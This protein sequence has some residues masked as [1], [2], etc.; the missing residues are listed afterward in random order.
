MS[1]PVQPATALV[2]VDDGVL[3]I[4]RLAVTDPAVLTAARSAQPRRESLADWARTALHA[5]AVAITAAG[6]GSDLAGV[7][8]ALD[9]L[10]RSVE[11]SVQDGVA[12][13][14]TG[15]DATVPIRVQAAIR[16]VLDGALP[17]ITR[18]LTATASET[19]RAVS[20][21]REAVRAAVSATVRDQCAELVRQIREIHTQL[22]LQAAF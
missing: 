11:N 19:Q 17:G 16:D 14:V 6:H 12:W 8:V 9:G 15:P 5:G 10:T 20:I 13:L 1:V 18:T 3:R 21:D 4:Q 2:A 7:R 22:A